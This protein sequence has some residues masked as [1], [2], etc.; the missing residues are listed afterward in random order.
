[1]MLMNKKNWAH[2]NKLNGLP[3]KTLSRKHLSRPFSPL[4]S[5]ITRKVLSFH[6]MSIFTSFRNPNIRKCPKKEALYHQ[7]GWNYHKIIGYMLCWRAVSMTTMVNCEPTM[8]P[9]KSDGAVMFGLMKTVPLCSYWYHDFV[10]KVMS[11][12]VWNYTQCAYWRRNRCFAR[13]I[14]CQLVM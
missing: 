3:R 5:N 7:Y 1:M 9:M 8:S 13:N 10:C 12:W 2:W 11:S 14:S 4:L 6:S